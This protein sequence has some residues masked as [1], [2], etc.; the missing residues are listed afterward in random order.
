MMMFDQKRSAS[1]QRRHAH[2]R[3]YSALRCKSGWCGQIGYSIRVGVQWGR[4]ERKD[5]ER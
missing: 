1:G 2:E 5:G 3:T 4:Q